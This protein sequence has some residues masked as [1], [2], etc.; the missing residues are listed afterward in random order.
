MSQYLIQG[1]T[2]TD[3]A[4]SI[5]SRTGSTDPIAVMDMAGQIEGII[6]G[7]GVPDGYVTVTF[8][9]AD[10]EGK[11]KEFSRLVMVGDDC[12]DPVMQGRIDTPTK[13]ST[14]DKVFTHNG[15]TTT[16]GGSADSTALQ[17]IAED[18]TVYAAYAAAVRYYTVTYYDEDS[19]TVLHTEQVAY[20]TTP[21]YE[22][23]KD[24]A[25]FAGWAPELAPVTGDASYTAVWS[26]ILAT[27]T[28]KESGSEGNWSLD[29]AYTLTV[30]GKGYIPHSADTT[31]ATLVPE[32]YREKVKTL[33]IEEGITDIG[34]YCFKQM[35][36]LTAVILPES[37]TRIGEQCFNGC[38]SLSTI[39]LPSE[40]TSIADRLFVNCKSLTSIIIPS[41]VTRFYDNA[42][43]GCSALASINIPIAVMTINARVFADC[44]ALTSAIFE[45]TEGWTAGTTALASADLADPATAAK[46]LTSTYYSKVWTKS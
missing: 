45:D 28:W 32:E 41:K 18:K 22:A 39:N 29:S 23:T 38:G 35:T 2:L 7:G 6:G 17:N 36:G 8:R 37:I 44:T 30:S 43:Y 5:R 42:F 31:K 27:G 19:T 14:V 26:S 1:A 11:P 34:D 13:E 3:I 4:D 20:G 9:Y 12:P 24:G 25:G 46:Y 33:V 10:Q 40:L 21:S 16:D 15:W